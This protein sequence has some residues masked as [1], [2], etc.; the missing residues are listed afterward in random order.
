M[1]NKK[2]PELL[3][4]AGSY[5][6]FVAAISAGAD[7]VYMGGTKHNARIGAKNFTNEELSR[8]IDEA[9]LLGRKVYMTLNTLVTDR[10]LPQV[11]DYVEELLTSGS[12][13]L[14]IQDLGLMSAISTVFPKAE[15]H[16]S[17]QCITHSIDGVKTLHGLGAKRAVVARELDK[18][19][20]SLICRESPIEIE[21]FV[22]GALCVCHS[23]A[24]LFS[25]LVGGRSGNRGECA[26]PCRLP[27]KVKGFEGEYPLSLCDLTLSRQLSELTEMGV[28]SLKIEGRMKSDIYVGSVV[29]IFRELLDMGRDADS[30]DVVRLADIFSRGGFTDGYYTGKLGKKMYGVRSAQDKETTRSIE[31]TAFELPKAPLDAKMTVTAQGAELTVTSGEKSSTAVSLPP[32]I[33]VNRPIDQEFAREQISK[34]G[35]T[36]FELNS[37]EF[38]SDG[39]YILPKSALNALRREAIDSLTEHKTPIRE[40]LAQVEAQKSRAYEK[41]VVLAPHRRDTNIPNGADRVY[42]PL[43]RVPCQNIEKTGVTLPIIITDT[44][45]EEV[46]SELRRLRQKGIKYAYA[47]SLG[48]AV[49]ALEEGFRVIGGVRIN[50]YN[51]HTLKVLKDLGFEGAVMS[52]ELAAPIKRDMIKSLPVGEIIR[53]RVPLMIMENCIMNLRDSCRECSDFKECRKHTVLTDRKG[54]SFPVYPEYFHRCQIYNSVTTYNGDRITNE[55]SFGIIYVTDEKSIEEAMSSQPPKEYTRKG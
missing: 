41:Y 29:K 34:L 18:D 28:S 39:D 36:V 37:F 50:A 19:N 13:A 3:A 23:G 5:A 44:Q 40:A 31:K 30:K 47:E 24:C 49:L 46:S 45:R 48:S 11:L 52:C 9:H 43:F 54:I 10:E 16:A 42:F 6:A 26:Q 33:A 2:I 12:D 17:T 35:Q 38:Y 32:D 51:S 21:A 25:S 55:A 53:G 8:A 22:H 1:I 15:L 27:Y 7:A 4:P 20:L 14:I